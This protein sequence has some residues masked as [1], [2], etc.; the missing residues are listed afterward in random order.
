MCRQKS[1]G[2]PRTH[3]TAVGSLAVK[4]GHNGCLGKASHQA[5][6]SLMALKASYSGLDCNRKREGHGAL[7]RA[8]WGS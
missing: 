8:A 3:L 5:G 1:G 6:P 4:Q 2:I 7:H